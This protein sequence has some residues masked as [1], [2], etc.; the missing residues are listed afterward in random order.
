MGTKGRLSTTYLVAAIA[1][2]LIAFAAWTP[3]ASEAQI[4]YVPTEDTRLWIEGTS[5]VR[6]FTC[7]AQIID[8]EASLDTG[9]GDARDVLQDDGEGAEEE[10]PVFLMVRVPVDSLK[11][12]RDRETRD[13]YR[14][15]KGDEY[16]E[17]VFELGDVLV[18]RA[19]D[20]REVANALH[21]SGDLTIAGV[22]R[23]LDLVAWA[24]ILEDGRVFATGMKEL[25]MTDFGMDPPRAM[26]GML[27]AHDDIEVHFEIYG[28]PA[29][30]E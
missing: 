29:S 19:P 23:T 26:L 30:D 9:P 18:T 16:P 27:R 2:L 15:M 17:I 14:T 11:C 24:D 6:D 22:T 20:G 28:R 12:E 8:G 4:R 7:E 25:A 3:T 13:L 1:V 10:D 21:V 5:T